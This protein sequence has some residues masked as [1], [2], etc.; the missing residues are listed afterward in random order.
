MIFAKVDA[1][2]FRERFIH[3][4][5]FHPVFQIFRFLRVRHCQK[6]WR[7]RASQETFSYIIYRK[8]NFV[9]LKFYYFCAVYLYNVCWASWKAFQVY[10]TLRWQETD[11]DVGKYGR[12]SLISNACLRCD[13]YTVHG[14][15]LLRVVF[16]TYQVERSPFRPLPRHRC[17]PF[18][19]DK[20]GGFSQ[21]RVLFSLFSSFE[22]FPTKCIIKISLRSLRE[23]QHDV[24]FVSNSKTF[25]VKSAFLTWIK[26]DIEQLLREDYSK[27]V[28]ADFN[29][30][31]IRM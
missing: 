4:R 23:Y 31:F 24:V 10:S 25:V 14:V 2:S 12:I 8:K 9:V 18:V 3:R 26:N 5:V 15:L 16:I 21:Q 29:N 30:N 28:N 27:L 19:F 20:L 22:T 6:N 7:C 1:S 17:F 11:D 13:V